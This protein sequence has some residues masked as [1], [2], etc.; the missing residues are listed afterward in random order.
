MLLSNSWE[1][2]SQ[3]TTIVIARRSEKSGKVAAAYFMVDLACLGVKRV[4]VKRFKDAEDYAAGLRADALQAQPMATVDLDLV[5]KIIYTALEYASTL[6]FKPD[7]VF[8]QA[9]PLL[10][11]RGPGSLFNPG[12]DWR[13]RGHTPICQWSL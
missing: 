4:R 5:A 7:F 2:T 13:T 11:R 1:D 3:L 10:S 6:G 12:A 9:E 8:A